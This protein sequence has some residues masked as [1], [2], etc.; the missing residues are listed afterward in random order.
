MQ[1]A[2]LKAQ[3]SQAL[4]MEAPKSVDGLVGTIFR[5]LAVLSR[6]VVKQNKDL[7]LS[8][9]DEA[10]QAIDIPR[11]PEFLEVRIEAYARQALSDGIDAL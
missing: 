8:F 6:E 7:I 4:T 3:L 10:C 2:E 5:R 9:Y 11:V 1:S